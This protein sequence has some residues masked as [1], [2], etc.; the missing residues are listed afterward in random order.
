MNNFH[1]LS[2]VCKPASTRTTSRT[3]PDELTDPDYMFP[4]FSNGKVLFGKKQGRLPAMGWNSWNAFGSKNNEE[5][6]KA[7][8]DAII[9]LGPDLRTVNNHIIT[10]IYFKKKFNLK[11]IKNHHF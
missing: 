8:T 7:M 1:N 3:A 11:I 2:A 4:A 9:N 10:N 5:L 6:T